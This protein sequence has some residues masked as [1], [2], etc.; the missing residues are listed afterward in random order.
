M[1]RF[2]ITLFLLFIS[3]VSFGQIYINEFMAS[4]ASTIKDPD[5]NNDA[6][7][8]ELYNDG[9]SAV[10]LDG[11]FITDN[12]NIPDK[13]RIS[14]II[15]PAKGY[16]IF[17]A[18]GMDTGN[19]TNFKLTASG[20]EIGL[21]KPDL[22]VLDTIRFANQNPDI[23]TGRNLE[24]LMLWGHFIVATPEA[25]N[26]TEFF[27]DFVLNEPMFNI[28][29]GL[30]NAGQSVSLFTDLGGEIRYTLDG[31]EPKLQSKLYSN[32]IQII[33]TTV[34][35]ARVFK[36]N[37]MPGPVITNTYFI[38]ENM[39][40]RGLPVVSLASDPGN[41]WDAQNGIYVQSFKPE[42]EIPVNI[43]LFENNQSD[44]AA[45]NEKA[46]V[47]VN[48][49]Y[50]W[51][52]PEKMLGVYF[53]KQYG[54]STLDNTLFYDSPR[55][56][57]KTFAL[58]AS[59]ND[60]SNTLMRD[61]L[62]QNA[63]QLNMHLDIS[64]FRWCIV[65]F[66][67][68]YMGIHNFREKI[69]TDYIEKHYG[70]AAGTFDMVENED[71]AECGDLNAYN[72]FKIQFSKDLS[73]QA[74]FDAVAEL[75][76]IED[77]TNLVITEAATGNSSVDHNVMAWKPKDSGM[78]NWI[79][80]DLDRGFT[81]VTS[82]PISFYT[83]QT[84][85]P[86]GR[87]IK[88][89]AYQSY[90]GK[91]LAD[92]L[93]SCFHPDEMKKLID[94]HQKTIEAE[95]PNHV[96]RWLGRTSS[97][98]N[99][100][101]SVDYWYNEV[102]KLRTFVEQ[103][104]AFLLDDLKNYGFTGTA[105]LMVSIFPE[106]AGTMYINGL[107]I[108]ESSCSGPYLKNVSS[109]L[110]IEE[111]AGFRFKGWT[112]LVKKVFVP[113]QSV[114]KYLDDGSNQGNVWTGNTFND[115][116]WKS[117]QGELGYGDGDEK[118]TVLYGSDG[119]NKYITTY[120][121]S[122]F[123][124]TDADKNASSFTINLLRDDGAVVYLNGVEVLRDNM[125]S[126]KIDYKS[127]ATTGIAG[128]AES[129]FTSFTVN[130]SILQVGTN[131]LAV[132]VHQNAGT[133][134]DISFDLELSVNTADNS[135]FLSTNKKYPFN[136]SDDLGL[137]AVFE[138][139]TDCRIPAVIAQSLTLH[140]SCSPYIVPENVTLNSGATLTIEPGVEIWMSPGVNI[141]INGNMKAIGTSTAPITFKINPKYGDQGWGSLSFWNTSDTSKLTYVIVDDA[142]K[143]PIPNRVGAING[144]FTTL[145]LDHLLIDKTHLNPIASRYSDVSLTNSYI[146]STAT[147]DLINIKYG[148]GRIE[149]CTFVG[150]PAFDSDGIDYD[151]ITDG[152]IRNVKLYNILGNNADAIDIGEEAINVMI[153]SV[154][155]Y[156][157]FD[158]GV[159]VGQRSSVHVTNSEFIN[160][161]MGFGV[162]DSS[163]ARIENCI[164]Y[165]NGIPVN[166]YEKN[167]GR[168]GGNAIVKNSILSN[169]SEA[170]WQAD[171]KST[172]KITN[173]IA[174]NTILPTGTGNKFGNPLFTDPTHQD[175]SLQKGSPA[176]GAGFENGQAIDMGTR[177]PRILM[178]PD[179]LICQ[180]YLN[181]LN[182]AFPEYI[183]LYN[184]SFNTLDLSGYS[185]DKG[186]TA[187]VPQGVL[188]APGDTLYLT[189][190]ILPWKKS[191]K[192]VQWTLGKLSNQ[193]ESIE[194]LNQFGMVADHV[195]YSPT[196]GWP[197]KA[198]NSETAL[199]LKSPKLDNHF[200]ENWETIPL[201]T[202]L[203]T[204]R[205]TDN[206]TIRV[207]PNPA[208]E[209]VN[210]YAKRESN[211]MAQM[212]SPTGQLIKQIKLDF[213]GTATIDV[214]NIKQG[215]YLL[216]IGSEIVKV[217]VSR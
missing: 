136:L 179:V 148:K 138:S 107:T 34:V 67:G 168:A 117:G 45:F 106:D 192:V 108:P 51:Q 18:D 181:P 41:F 91:K 75:M 178:E 44:R 159:S 135:G 28:R 2:K 197:S 14:N 90:F 83:G 104:P 87:L 27:S 19:H 81:N 59:G 36:P 111:K 64:H 152:I 184:A 63:T 122:S 157:A 113:K 100:M 89:K 73:V 186:I 32:P 12:F 188:L 22:S 193:G 57:F 155:I 43:E 123:I 143:G 140:K 163:W 211:Q 31:S 76:D 206:F 49:L 214:S 177:M 13:W 203:S 162:K 213:E 132:E 8:F 174:D 38:N 97:Y 142:T 172:I 190:D 198:F 182:T 1:I 130:K 115:T 187:I 48:G 167:L 3:V 99:A 80:M 94:V 88:N 53:K 217:L 11:Y 129:T 25:P 86:F 146:H 173:S 151:G 79:L 47:K 185:I 23:S 200:P 120:F 56:G 149:N 85:F 52:L 170:S 164:F 66:N 131:I 125:G 40:A 7:W 126:G 37:M 121:R 102:N 50:S 39:K 212:Y 10:N 195:K 16:K 215:I 15:I 78:W 82:Q 61:I 105:N 118:T 68:Q 5:Y 119:Q 147:S 6:D 204:K 62:G 54:T 112:G 92:H 171:N 69:E 124:L 165:G 33:V 158:K 150:N 207:Y 65:Y 55:A 141:F 189:S 216:R 208:S 169:S 199:S 180:I 93:F 109:E 30:Y 176:I 133:S 35:R 191:L 175:F 4:N 96:A 201:G 160:C 46:G 114:W 71:Y 17:W 72:D 9:N 42:W 70:L 95:I 154:Q 166:C 21:Y 116:S 110:T 127:L 139:T 77:F 210:V 98:G 183:A 134:S 156:N 84:S 60:W 205:I 29:G 137:I 194:L 103:R 74:N 128:T 24:N 20:E 145:R 58:R 101:P 209:K 144:Y 202:I 196:T 153:D 161:N 26:K